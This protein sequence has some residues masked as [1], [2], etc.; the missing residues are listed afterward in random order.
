VKRGRLK[1][2]E[3]MVMEVLERE[4]EEEREEVKWIN[5]EEAAATVKRP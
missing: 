4:G 5:E 1:K 3:W 2:L